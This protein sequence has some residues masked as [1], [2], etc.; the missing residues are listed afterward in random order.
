[1]YRAGD[2]AASSRRFAEGGGGTGRDDHFACEVFMFRRTVIRSR[3][4][5]SAQHFLPDRGPAGPPKSQGCRAGPSRLPG[6]R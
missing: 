4:G 1:M 2:A 6:A 3:R 5:L